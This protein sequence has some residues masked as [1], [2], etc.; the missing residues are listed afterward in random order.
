MRH[1]LFVTLASAATLLSPSILEA[2]T[3]PSPYEHIETKHSFN[4]GAGYMS[5]AGGDYDV[6]PS[7]GPLLTAGYTYHFTGPLSGT[8]GVSMIPTSRTVYERLTISEDAYELDPI[9]EADMLMTVAEAGLRFTL[10]GARTWN[11]LAPYVGATA[12]L[13]ANLLPRPD[14][15]QEIETAQHVRLGP[16]FA[17]GLNAGADWFLSERMSLRV[18]GRN[19]LWRLATPEGLT[20]SQR[21]ESQWTNNLGIAFGA[22]L[23]F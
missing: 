1:A 19:Y 16:A 7:G 15:E 20:L 8:V 6:G 3:I 11:D 14:V 21:R 13:M 12:G 2:Q 22:A 4:F 18:E 17:L 10:T 9:G 5:L 23:H